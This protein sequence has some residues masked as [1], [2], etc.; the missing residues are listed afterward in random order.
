MTGPEP[1]V[2]IVAADLDRALR[3]GI[4]DGLLRG[5]VVAAGSGTVPDL[6]WAGGLAAVLPAPH[7]MTPDA[8]FDIASITKVVATATACGIL[9]DRGELDP[10]APVRRYLPELP[11]WPGVDIRIRDMATHTSGFENHH[12]RGLPREEMMRLLFVTPTSWPPRSRFEYACRNF[13]L[14][15]L[16][17][18]RIAGEPL[19]DFCRRNIFE[20]IGMTSSFSY[21]PPDPVLDR[22]V[23]T[24]YPAPYADL[25]S[26]A[27]RA[28]RM[29]GHAG[30]F[31][32]APD[33]ARFSAMMLNRGRVGS[34]R[35]LGETA[36]E[37]ILKP[38]SPPGLPARSFGWDM[39]PAIPAGAAVPN[40]DTAGSPDRPTGF[41]ASAIG[42]SGWTGQSLWIDPERGRYAM[43]LTNRTHCPSNSANYVPSKRFRA[44]VAELALTA[45]RRR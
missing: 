42:H 45:E 37:W 11:E 31:T 6:L 40:G 3:E 2:A 32:N 10:E 8:I 21:P 25:D 15:G 29:I 12:F 33:L 39:R 26:M 41:S 13:I 7:P 30:L 28:G 4:A 20:P 5:M 18:E 38:C 27:R 22:V 34:T 1:C 9:M 36:L 19:Y 17:V 16:I 23:P 14:L 43:V 44:R 24:A 35:I